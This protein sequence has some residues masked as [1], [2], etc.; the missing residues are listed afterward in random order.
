MEGR[1]GVPRSSSTIHPLVVDDAPL[2]IVLYPHPVLGEVAAEVPVVDESVRGLAARMIE[3]MYEADGV[4]LAAP[5]VG[6][7]L[8]M[9]VADAQESEE[10]DP[11][12]FINPEI[13][14]SGQMEIGGGGCLSIP[15]NPVMVRRPVAARITATGLDGELVRDG[16]R[17]LPGPRLAARVRSSRR[18]ADHRPDDAAG[19]SGPPT[20]GLEGVASVLRVSGTD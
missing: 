18:H 12:V 11:V 14:I 8:R 5:Q 2:Q 4:G 3:A 20:G 19:S 7:A 9:F 16:E 10:P 1:A 6:H 17:R 13:T 15:E